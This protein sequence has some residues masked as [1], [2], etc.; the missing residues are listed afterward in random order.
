MEGAQL[1]KGYLL[2]HNIG[3]RNNIGSI[4]RTACAFNL[5]KIFYVGHHEGST[6]AKVMKDFSFFGNKGTLKRT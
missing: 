3:K 1:K 2:L 5:S 6:K 4:I